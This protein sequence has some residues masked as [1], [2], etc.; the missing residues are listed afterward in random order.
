MNTLSMTSAVIGLSIVASGWSA[1]KD[2]PRAWAS[3]E[4]IGM[5]VV[6]EQG[7]NLGK[8]EDIVVRPSGDSS[9]A[10]LSFGGTLGM[11]DKLF[12][13]PWSVL[14]TVEP[15]T[16]KKDSTRSLV[17]PL[18]KERLKTAP[19]F[20]KNTWP[21][22]ANKDWTKDIDAFY[23]GDFNPNTKRP[24]DAALRMPSITWRVSE[25]KGT[26]VNTPSGTKLGDLQEL[27]IDT[28]GRVAYATI[29]VGGFLGMGEKHVPV[30]WDMLKLSVGG[31]N[32]D[33]KMI[34]LATTKEQLEKAP[35]FK[36]GKEHCAEMCDP[37]W[38]GRVYEHFSVPAYWNNSATPIP[39]IGSKN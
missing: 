21:N 39:K 16:A 10:V 24:V 32:G 4:L 6:S 22:M 3:T 12:A 31:D 38:I 17:L 36:T 2:A 27:V 29:S 9:Y 30:P 11:G 7:D 14:R 34:S 33:T 28:D 25:I 8:I 23:E 35:E 20:D 15:D 19:G 37:K 13:M 1:I 5:K 18:V 26:N